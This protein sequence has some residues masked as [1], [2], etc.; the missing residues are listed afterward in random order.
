MIVQ[1]ADGRILLYPQEAHAHVAGEMAAELLGAPAPRAAFVA[2]VRVH[3][4]G[5]READAA[6][7]LNGRTGLPHSFNDYP[8]AGYL[9]IWR[10]GISRA[11][12]LDAHVGLL[13]SLHG[14]RFFANDT[15]PELRAFYE[16]QRALQD[17]LLRDLGLGGRWD[18]LPKEVG[19]QVAWMRF[20][21]GL[22][23][24][25]CGVWGSP[26]TLTSPQGEHDV[27]R[28]DGRLVVDPWPFDEEFDVAI[29]ARELDRTRRATV[30]EL[31]RDHEAA[32]RRLV[33]GTVAVA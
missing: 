26:R 31:R 28:I 7:L 1:E 33:Q 32:P 17:S 20:F 13:V 5:W 3:D 9:D 23:L 2:A 29:Q 12:A 11:V 8:D 10:R 21:D 6:P 27:E 24:F 25:F 14:A 30:D 22:S 16:E 19:D 4:N 18:A 15:K